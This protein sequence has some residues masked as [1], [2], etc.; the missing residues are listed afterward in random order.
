MPRTDGDLV[1]F[2]ASIP[3]KDNLEIYKNVKYPVNEK[4]LY[5]YVALLFYGERYN[6]CPHKFHLERE[7]M[8]SRFYM[9][10]YH[11]LAFLSPWQHSPDR[12]YF[13]QI[14]PASL[15]HAILFID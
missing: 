7:L 1:H 4:Y 15:L 12:S 8:R 10:L 2:T 3:V 14:L 6:K 9:L 5:R 11:I 13:L